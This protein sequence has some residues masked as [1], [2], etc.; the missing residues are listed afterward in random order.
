MEYNIRIFEDLYLL[1]NDTI[2]MNGGDRMAIDSP[3]PPTLT[4]DNGLQS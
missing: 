3:T 1:D 2:F 4:V